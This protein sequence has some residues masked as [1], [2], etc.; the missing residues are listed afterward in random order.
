MRYRRM[1][2]SRDEVMEALLNAAGSCGCIQRDGD[3]G[4]K[5]RMDVTHNVA[6]GVVIA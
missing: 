3:A 5:R 4:K 1:R 6:K 2:T